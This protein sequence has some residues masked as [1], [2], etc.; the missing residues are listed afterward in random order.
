MRKV[1]I[2]TILISF[3]VISC[4]RFKVPESS[5]VGRVGKTLIFERDIQLT[6]SSIA[7][8][9]P[10]LEEKLTDEVA[11]T[12][13]LKGLISEEICR[14]WGCNLEKVITRKEI[15]NLVKKC[16]SPSLLK[17]LFG[18]NQ[19][20][21]FKDFVIPQLATKKLFERVYNG[22]PKAHNKIFKKAINFLKNVKES[23]DFEYFAKKYQARLFRVTLEKGKF[24]WTPVGK[25]YPYGNPVTSAED[26]SLYRMV[27]KETPA[28][29]VFPKVIEQVGGF[30]VF[31][32]ISK[33]RDSA[34]L[35]MAYFPKK[36]WDEFYSEEAG[37][38]NI[39]MED[40]SY[41]LAIKDK[42]DWLPGIKIIY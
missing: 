36:T 28:G 25:R 15:D 4:D 9:F 24:S 41:Y 3:I 18:D 39:I 42:V 10:N 19:K 22:N 1:V 7:A 33:N 11:F 23:G 20:L 5:L 14:E 13:L 2:L 21:F 40:P 31:K 12:Y 34:S 27:L 35:L 30:E 37:K 8:C 32:V 29:K 16:D 38:L 6:R 17:E 26:T